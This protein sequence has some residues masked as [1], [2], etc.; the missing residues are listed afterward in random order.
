MRKHTD[1]ELLNELRRVINILGRSPKQEEFSKLGN[2]SINSYKRAFGGLSKA[3]ILLGEKPTF[4]RG[5]TR[6]DALKEIKKVYDEFGRI[7]TTEE[8][9]KLSN[10]TFATLRNITN[11]QSWH[12]LLK[13]VGVSDEEFVGKMK[14]NI[15]NDEL[16]EEILR[17][18]NIYGRYPTYKEM[19]VFGKF[20]CNLYKNKFGGWSKAFKA[21]GFDDYVSQ[22]IYKAQIHSKGNDD[23][24]YKSNFESRIANLLLKL[25]LDNEIKNYEYEVKVSNDRQWTCD[26]VITKNDN[27]K[28]WVECDGM[29]DNRDKPYNEDNEK[30]KYYKQN[31]MN[32]LIIPYK[33]NYPLQN[34]LQNIWYDNDTKPICYGDIVLNKYIIKESNDI[35][36]KIYLDYAFLYFRSNGFPYPKYKEKDLNKEWERLCNFDCNKILEG[37]IISD[38]HTTGTKIIKHFSPH[39]FE[40]KSFKKP[41]LVEAFYDDELLYKCLNNRMGISYKEIFN[42]TPAMV[43]QGFRSTKLSFCVSIFKPI[44]AKFIYERYTNEGDIVYDYSM[45]FGQRFMGAMSSKN[46]LFYIGCDPWKNSI[47]SINKIAKCIKQDRYYIE[48]IGSEYFCPKEYINKVSLAF[49][50]PPYFDLEIYDNN[51]KTQ[52]YNKGYEAYIEWF[53]KTLSNIKLLLK[54]DG[55]FALNIKKTLYDDIKY[56]FEDFELIDTFYIK[57]Y[58]SKFNKNKNL[59]PIYIMKKIKTFK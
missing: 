30:I 58:R 56:I 53:K 28:L 39:I 32:Y 22:S 1:E 45:G 19:T 38:L 49:S 46:N 52:A 51:N 23:I 4:I 34:I 41:S 17:L 11:N 12:S 33:W 9:S 27:S 35:K 37:N 50:S 42:I 21:L 7:P 18:K 13:E 8:F 15:T 2:I 47:N 59:E 29:E 55:V 57:L 10:M 25:K 26:F 43:R 6:E 5:Q 14:K 48:N 24:I 36:R 54:E 20:S 44:I 31:K 16:K 40:V 3:L